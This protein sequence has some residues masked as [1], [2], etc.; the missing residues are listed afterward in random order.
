VTVPRRVPALAVVALLAAAALPLYRG[1]AELHALEPLGRAY[2]AAAERVLEL[3]NVAVTRDGAVLRHSPSFAVEVA[4][5][6]TAWLH[7]ALFVAGLLAIDRNRR[8]FRWVL[9]GTATLV[10]LNV[11]RIAGLYAAGAIRPQSFE[12][13]HRALGEA[14]LAAAVLFLWSQATKITEARA[15][16]NARPRGSA[17]SRDPTPAHLRSSAAL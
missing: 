8:A 1:A 10:V 2:A 15:T 12:W 11:V 13:A 9:A 3:A 16:G 14:L 7:I 17:G 4:P 5:H 6:C